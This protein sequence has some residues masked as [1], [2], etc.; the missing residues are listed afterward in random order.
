MMFLQG[1]YYSDSSHITKRF[2]CFEINIPSSWQYISQK[3]IDS[4]IGI[5]LTENNDTIRFDYG[6]YSPTLTETDP[7][8]IPNDLLSQFIESGEDT[9][10]YI[11]VQNPL[12]VDLDNYRKQ[13]VTFENVNGY[14]AKITYPREIGKGITGLYVKK[15]KDGNSFSIYGFN[16][17]RKEHELLLEVAKTI[18]FKDC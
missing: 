14:R 11:F 17:C 7:I 3:G 15:L 12:E 10:Q 18:K 1:C 8:I 16:L 5:F 4:S 2:N 13:N 6:L 9:S